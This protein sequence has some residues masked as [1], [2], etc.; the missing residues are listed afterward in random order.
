MAR[1]GR[2]LAPGPRDAPFQYVDVRDLAELLLDSSPGPRNAICPPLTWGEFLETVRAV[3]GAP[4]AELVWTDAAAVHAAIPDSWDILPVWPAPDVPH[5]YAVGTQHPYTP[6]SVRDT[7][8]AAWAAMPAERRVPGL[9]PDLEAR[10]LA[11]TV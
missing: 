1:G 6:R 3:A 8:E 2:V 11:G 7:V 5:A 10:I 4:D 9:D